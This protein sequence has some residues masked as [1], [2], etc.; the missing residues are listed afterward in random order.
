MAGLLLRRLAI[1]ILVILVVSAMTFILV[2][3]VPG[4]PAQTIL[5]SKATPASIA[6]LTHQLHLDEP[7]PVQY[8]NWLTAAVR[9]NLGTSLLNGQ[10]VASLM[11]SR[12]EPTLSLVLLSTLVSLVSAI[13]LGVG[14]ALRGGWFTRVVDTI[15]MVGLAVPGFLVGLLLAYVFASSLHVF[16]VEGY[17]P[18][19]SGVPT[20]LQALVLPVIAL[21]VS[22]IGFTAKQVRQTM[23]E[24]LESDFV[25]N[26]NANGL[27]RRSVIYKHALRN[28]IVPALALI[29]VQLAGAIGSTVL[30]ETVFGI[31]GVGGLAVSSVT[32]QDLPVVLATTL[33]LTAFVVVV[34]LVLDVA[35]GLLNPKVRIA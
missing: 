14:S 11:A 13:T 6:Q 5:G 1:G 24:V 31:P 19:S 7:L 22:S 25:F 3:L 10:P 28:A 29:G 34:N 30:I 16:P 27:R 20:W 8:L 33:F 4:N 9:G 12:I 15:G 23:Q 26:L 17:N 21:S 18:L 2:A 32:Q 35:Y